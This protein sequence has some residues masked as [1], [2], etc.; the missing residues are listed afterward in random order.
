M[1][2]DRVL[3][4]DDEAAIRFGIGEFLRASDFVVVEADSCAA[5]V[6]AFA[7]ETPDIAVLDYSLG[8]GNGLDLLRKLRELDAQVPVILLTAH[9]TI[10]LAVAA[11]K[12]GAD[13]FLTKPVEL[14]A[15]RVVL[16]RALE[17][18]RGRKK[19]LARRKREQREEIDAFRGK[20]A[21]IRRLADDARRVL[22]SDRPIFIHGETGAG[23]GVLARWI[24]QNGPRANE[25]FVDMNCAGLSRELLESELFGHERGAF[26]GAVTAKQGLLEIAHRGTLFLDEV[27]DMD[28]GIQAKLLKVLE[29]R[30]YRRVGD[31]HDRKVDLRLVTATHHDL[32]ALVEQ[33]KFRRDL[34][35]RIGTLPLVVPPL[36]ERREDIA[37]LAE[38]FAHR[39]AAE[40]GRGELTI[41]R[42]AVELLE[43][44]RWTGNVRELRNAI[45]RA[46]LLADEGRIGAGELHFLGTASGGSSR[47]AEGVSVTSTHA[48]TLAELE[49]IYIL[50]VMDEEGGRV[51]QVA[52]RLDIPR[53]SL[54]SRLKKYGVSKG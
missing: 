35:Y 23:K 3:I 22:P 18:Q 9:G 26:T 30:R 40:L 27:G 7:A 6:R 25:A 28:L 21:A 46:V 39:F 48:G 52:R 1:A 32:E 11:V 12:E 47:A 41:T 31:V 20:S 42:E 49:R 50:R 2:G 4:V 15:L 34:Y 38:E 54:Y 51:D 24:H 13:Q 5:A 33:G 14:P 36:R 19:G 29:D 16:E 17:H 53:S 45:E 37:H 44:N 43:R 10:D 8:D